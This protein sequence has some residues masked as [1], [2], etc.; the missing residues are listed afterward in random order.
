MANRLDL[1][2]SVLSAKLSSHTIGGAVEPTSNPTQPTMVYDGDCCFCRSWIRRLE[3]TT[4]DRVAYAPFQDVAERFTHIPREDFNRAVHLIE[5][6]GDTTNAARAVCRCLAVGADKRWPLLLYDRVPGVARIA[7]ATYRTVTRHRRGLS[8][9]TRWTHGS[10]SEPT[11]YVLMRWLFIRLLAAIYF[12]AFVSL[13]VQIDG[14]IGSNGILPAGEYLD[15]LHQ[16]FGD[17]AYWQFPTVAWLSCSDGFLRALCWGSAA[18]SVLVMF[19][20]LPGPMLLVLWGSYLSLFQIGQTFLSFQWDILLLEVGFLGILFASWRPWPRLRSDEP[21]QWIVR[22]LIILLLF[23]L[24]FSSGVVK[25][26]DENPDQATWHALTAL[27]YHFETQCIPNAVAWYAHN[28]P[29]WCHKC[30][31]VTMFV[32]EIGVPFL[33]FLPR[34]LRLVG[35]LTQIFFQLLILLT[36][37]YNF[38]NLL[39]IVLCV[40]LLDDSFIRRFFPKR[41]VVTAAPRPNRPR[42]WLLRR[43]LTWTLAVVLLT[44]SYVWMSHTLRSDRNEWRLRYDYLP[45]AAEEVVRFAMRFH[46]V[47]S[48]GLFR[49]MTT[50]RPE[51]I[52]EGSDDREHWKAYEFKWK[53]GDPKRRPSQVAPHQPRLDWQMWF[54]ALGDFRSRQNLWFLRFEKRLLEGSPEVLGLLAHNPFPDAPPKYIRAVLYDYHFTDWDTRSREKTWW[55]RTRLKDYTPVLTLESFRR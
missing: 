23:R 31:V 14:L 53:Q 7:E 42:P 15:L 12:I 20:V 47:N 28:L 49:T 52:V 41:I 9:L 39:T 33:F 55:T 51:I 4:G 35:C 26:L 46:S 44:M 10:V 18:I 22:W 1:P 11:S 48:Y 36:G 24:M 2:P 54:A 29:E 5:P 45:K 32:I 16:Q 6:G 25:L 13:G 38:F 19:R 21:P 3:W 43:V 34:R 30:S 17:D 50:R 27:N 40:A 37:N 8:T